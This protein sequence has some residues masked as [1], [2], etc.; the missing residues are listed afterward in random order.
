M[1]HKLNLTSEVLKI[2]QI[3]NPLN[4]KTFWWCLDLRSAGAVASPRGLPKASEIDY[5]A[6]LNERTYNKLIEDLA[7]HELKL[8]GAKVAIVGEITLDQ[9]MDIVPGEIGVIVYTIESIEVTKIK[10]RLSEEADAAGEA[11]PVEQPAG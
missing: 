4:P 8:K 6:I 2:R 10:R 3:R 5:T 7:A 11:P 1:P 9:P